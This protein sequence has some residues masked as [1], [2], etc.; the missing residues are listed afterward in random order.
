MSAPDAALQLEVRTTGKSL[1][2]SDGKSCESY[3]LGFRV[4]DRSWGRYATPAD[5]PLQDGTPYRELHVRRWGLGFV[6]HSRTSF[7]RAVPN[8]NVNV[9]NFCIACVTC[10]S[11]SATAAAEAAT[12]WVAD[13]CTWAL[14][15]SSASA[16]SC[17]RTA[18]RT[19][20]RGVRRCAQVARRLC[21]SVARRR[22][23]WG[24]V[25]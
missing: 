7:C 22:R 23:G 16:P 1:T 14:R 3:R 10:S 25:I 20:G 11:T 21:A 4:G 12:T 8:P 17:R 9:R 5:F 18:C 15:P 24:C 6:H 13:R 19:C 2:Y